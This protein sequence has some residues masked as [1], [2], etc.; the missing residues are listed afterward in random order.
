LNPLH[1]TLAELQQLLEREHY[2]KPKSFLMT[3]REYHR[4]RDLQGLL[5]ELVDRF[6]K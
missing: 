5:S 1:Q 2:L 6:A 3:R 4:S